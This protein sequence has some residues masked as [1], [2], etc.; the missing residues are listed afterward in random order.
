MRCRHVARVCAD[1]HASTARSNSRHAQVLL[2][3]A[4]AGNVEAVFMVG[5]IM[6]GV[7]VA[8]VA[9]RGGDEDED[10][11]SVVD[12]AVRATA[13]AAAAS[14]AGA[15]RA[16]ETC[17]ERDARLAAGA[18]VLNE[19]CVFVCVSVCVF[20]CVFVCLYV[21]VLFVGCEW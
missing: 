7:N 4:R 5:Y 1:T 11:A 3:L 15:R 10:D 20:V 9:S 16:G 8:G 13:T 12:E 21:C 14:G 2:P 19:V 17:A 18:A 6:Y